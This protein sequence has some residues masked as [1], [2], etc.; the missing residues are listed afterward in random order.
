MDANNGFPN[1]SVF[2]IEKKSH[3][4]CN[5]ISVRRIINDGFSRT[6]DRALTYG[7]VWVDESSHFVVSGVA[8]CTVK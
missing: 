8:S 6:L 1:C 7:T 5:N 3:V 2:W 4:L